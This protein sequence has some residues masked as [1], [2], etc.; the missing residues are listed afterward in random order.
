MNAT[1]E[2]SPEENSVT[3]ILFKGVAYPNVLKQKLV[4]IPWCSRVFTA[5]YL[6]CSVERLMSRQ[7]TNS[8]GQAVNVKIKRLEKEV[9]G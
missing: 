5:M 8:N 4:P 1:T 7:A 9:Y 3:M 2:V 6:K